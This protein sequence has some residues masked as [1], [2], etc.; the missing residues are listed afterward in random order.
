MKF[1]EQWPSQ[2]F[3]Y[4]VSRSRRERGSHIC[5]EWG[6]TPCS[7][8]QFYQREWHFNIELETVTNIAS[9]LASKSPS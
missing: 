5:L 4:S 9:E 6:E 1:R 2:E 8:S 7:L 3:I